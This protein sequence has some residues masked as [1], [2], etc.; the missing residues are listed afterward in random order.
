MNVYKYEKPW[1]YHWFMMTILK[2]IAT[3]QEIK[4]LWFFSLSANLYIIKWALLNAP[5][6]CYKFY[7]HRRGGGGC[8]GRR[9]RGKSSVSI[10]SPE[11]NK[12]IIKWLFLMLS[13]FRQ[14]TGENLP[15]I[16]WGWLELLQTLIQYI[17][18]DRIE[19][20]TTTLKTAIRI[21]VSVY[22]IA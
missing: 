8:V 12:T 5:G 10:K 6:G 16:T 1:D 20:Q 13:R 9:C 18:V 15:L 2:L 7:I 4:K 14:D 11:N 21:Q 17:Y 3:W 19:G 22:V